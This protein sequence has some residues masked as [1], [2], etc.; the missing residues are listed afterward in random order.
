MRGYLRRSLCGS[1]RFD[2]VQRAWIGILSGACGVEGCINGEFQP[3]LFIRAVK[4]TQDRLIPRLLRWARNDINWEWGQ[5]QATRFD[6]EERRDINFGPPPLASPR[7]N[8]GIL[9]SLS[10][11]YAGVN[12]A[13]GG[14]S[15]ASPRE[16]T[17]PEAPGQAKPGT[18]P[19]VGSAGQACGSK[20]FNHASC[21]Q[22]SICWS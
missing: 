14:A 16:N 22:P 1:K 2:Y 12:D 5:G 20:R 19:A 10:T 17:G 4:N 9:T 18:S 6:P 15:S 11:A 8:A 3:A 13:I 21:A 7:K